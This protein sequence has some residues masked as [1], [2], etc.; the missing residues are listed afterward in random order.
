MLSPNTSSQTVWGARPTP[1][2]SAFSRRHGTVLAHY[3]VPVP[4]QSGHRR[5]RRG[6]ARNGAPRPARLAQGRANHAGWPN[7]NF[8]Q[9]WYG[10]ARNQ[11]ETNLVTARPLA[12]F[13]SPLVARPLRRSRSAEAFQEAALAPI[14]DGEVGIEGTGGRIASLQRAPPS[15]SEHCANR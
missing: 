2:E 7:Q 3:L 8:A 13:A 5:P 12:P 6:A 15:S 4:G 1:M 11:S 9:R 10:S 14:L